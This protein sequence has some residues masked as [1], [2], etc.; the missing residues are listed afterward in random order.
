MYFIKINERE[1]PTPFYY[2]VT[3]KDIESSDSHRYDETGLVHRNRIRRSVKVCEVKW[4]IPGNMLETLDTDLSAPLL[5][6]SLLDPGSAGY[7]DCEMYADSISS[8]FYQQQN[9][10]ESASWWEISCRLTEF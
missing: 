9:N 6:V 5:N 2:S 1:L 7:V 8:E 10:S 4:R 3:S